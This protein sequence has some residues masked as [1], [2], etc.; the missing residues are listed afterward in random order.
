[1]N[2]GYT[3]GVGAHAVGRAVGAMATHGGAATSSDATRKRWIKRVLTVV[4]GFPLAIKVLTHDVPC[5]AMMLFFGIACHYEFLV[6]LC[7]RIHAALSRT[8]AT[9]SS[10]VTHAP[11]AAVGDDAPLAPTTW[12]PGT[13]T[14]LWQRQPC[15]SPA[16]WHWH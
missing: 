14:Y 9:G 13:R 6:H 7:P 4:I 15:G 1:M 5:M 11:A 12:P 8:T 3:P 2:D 10:E 16:A